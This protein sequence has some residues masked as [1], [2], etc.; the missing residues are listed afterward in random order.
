MLVSFAAKCSTTSTVIVNKNS[1]SMC[2]TVKHCVKIQLNIQY[3]YIC[4]KRTYAN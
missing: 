1:K 3:T 4:A 2:R